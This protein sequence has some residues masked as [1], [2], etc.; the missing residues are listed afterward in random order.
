MWTLSLDYGVFWYKRKS[1][2]ST[3]FYFKIPTYKTKSR[4]KIS[5][6]SL[7][8][9]QWKRKLKL[10]AGQSFGVAYKAK[11]NWNTVVAEAFAK[12]AAS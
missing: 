3:D 1:P 2:N 9:F 11:F 8:E 6:D 5:I 10:E 7:S 12:W 4:K